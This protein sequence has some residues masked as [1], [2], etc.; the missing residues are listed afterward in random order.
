MKFISLFVK[1]VF[2]IVSSGICIVL[3]TPVWIV[4]SIMIKK[5]QKDRFSS[6]RAEEPK[7]DGYFKC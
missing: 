5:I 1:R 6:S 7:M 4:V 2:D 3:L